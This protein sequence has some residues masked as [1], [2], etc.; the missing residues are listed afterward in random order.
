MIKRSSAAKAA[1][2]LERSTA[3][4]K[5][6]PLQSNVLAG[7]EALRHRDRSILFWKSLP[8]S[9][10]ITVLAKA[11]IV[12]L[13][14]PLLAWVIAEITGFI[15]LVWSSL[16][17]LVSGLPATPLWTQLGLFGDSFGLLYHLVTV[18][19][20][21]YAPLYGWLLLIS[22]WA[23]RAPFLWAVLPPFVLGVIE[24]LVFN[25]QHFGRFL[26][27]RFGAGAEAVTAPGATHMDSTTQL[28]PL[29]FLASPGLWIGL[30]FAAACLYGAARIRR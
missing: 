21:W 15:M 1:S 16:V 12:F 28:T 2:N 27:E 9:D 19:I 20:F 22:A 3:R 13:A 30:A 26:G 6:A 18:H 24:R 29:H 14:L 11:T 23:R 17:L 7:L 25:T 10:L 8:V 5:G 4:L